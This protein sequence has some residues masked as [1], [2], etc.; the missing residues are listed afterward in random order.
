MYVYRVG[1]L[2]RTSQRLY[3]PGRL[4]MRSAPADLWP[5]IEVRNSN[6]NAFYLSINTFDSRAFLRSS[7]KST[8]FNRKLTR[9][10]IYLTEKPYHRV[11]GF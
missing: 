8:P 1:S 6:G 11:N 10:F 4:A 2:C 7:G 5:V 3:S 9:N